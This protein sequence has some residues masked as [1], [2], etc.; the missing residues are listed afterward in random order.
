MKN[1]MTTMSM[2]ITNI[3]T[4]NIALVGMNTT[5]TMNMIIMDTAIKS[6]ST[7]NIAVVDM[8]TTA[9]MN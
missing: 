8:N 4:M 2:N 5:T 1:I 7:M 6:I 3:A 9:T